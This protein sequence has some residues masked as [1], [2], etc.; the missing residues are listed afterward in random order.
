VLDKAEYTAFESML[1]SPIVSYRIPDG[2][3]I[4]TYA[5][6]YQAP[7]SQTTVHPSR[8]PDIQVNSAPRLETSQM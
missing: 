7:R 3:T 2:K 1:N 8:T 6:N 5:N 4:R